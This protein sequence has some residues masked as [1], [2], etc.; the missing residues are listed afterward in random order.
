MSKENLTESGSE[1]ETS[2]LTSGTITLTNMSYP[3]LH[4]QSPNS[5]Q[6]VLRVGCRLELY[7]KNAMWP[8]NP[9]INPLEMNTNSKLL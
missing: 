4:W 7:P 1:P 5:Q 3:A 6:S 2:G 8:G 9:G